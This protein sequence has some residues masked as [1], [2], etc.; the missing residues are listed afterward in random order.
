MVTMEMEQKKLT[1]EEVNSFLKKKNTSMKEKV[2]KKQRAVAYRQVL[3]SVGVDN[4]A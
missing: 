1:Q 3:Q 4:L 2:A